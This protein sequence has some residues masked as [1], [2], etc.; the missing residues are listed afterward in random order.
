MLKFHIFS[1]SAV[2]FPSSNDASSLEVEQLRNDQSI[3][4][5]I[6]RIL[7][8]TTSYTEYKKLTNIDSVYDGH[9]SQT[10]ECECMDFWECMINDGHVFS[11]CH[12][13]NQVCCFKGADQLGILPR[14]SKISQCGQKGPDGLITGESA[15]G[16]FPWHT[17]LLEKPYDLYVCGASLVDEHWVLTAAHCVDEF[18]DKATSLKVR[19]GEHDVSKLT[20]RYRHEEFS[21][22][23]IILHHG[24]DN[25]TL[26]HDIALV[27]LE[28]SVKR[29]PHIDL[30]CMPPVQLKVE[31]LLNTECYITGWG[32]KN[33]G[34]AHSTVLKEV[35]V[36]VWRSNE[37][38][39]ALQK[40]FGPNF[41]LPSTNLCAGALGR[42]ACD[43]D[44]GGPLVCRMEDNKWTQV[45]I[46]SFGIGCGRANIPGVYTKVDQYTDWI[47]T[48]VLTN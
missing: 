48:T 39:K 23:K 40:L 18:L 31:K 20:E 10:G 21:V 17:A 9:S 13:T 45:G 42:D 37:C 11:Y 12:G 26:L 14:P 34:S 33:E 19:L 27:K 46:V 24:F 16:E 36:P 15:A 35:K 1:F 43:G 6:N 4:Y 28:T 32:R 3:D 7:N 44:G 2:E 25:S 22:S 29:R 38:Q 30:I 47:H 41:R 5:V 8:S